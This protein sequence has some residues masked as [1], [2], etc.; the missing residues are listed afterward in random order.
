MYAAVAYIEKKQ[1]NRNIN[2]VGTRGKK[3]SNDKGGQTFELADGYRVLEDIKMTPNYW[4][5]AK[6]EMIAR[7]DNLGP[8]QL[9]FTLSCADMRW[10]ENFAAILLERGYEID[11]TQT[12]TLEDGSSETNIRARLKG[13]EWKPIKKFIEENLEESIHELVRG[14]VLTATRYFEH[15]VKQFIN[16]VMMGRNNPMH[17]KYYTY[18]VEFQDRGAGHIHGTLWLDIDR[19]ENM[20]IDSSSGRFRPKTEEEQKDVNC[21]G[22]MHGLKSAFKKLRHDGKL[23][24][25]E[26]E[27]LRKFIDT[28]T[29]V[30]THENTIGKRVA[31]IA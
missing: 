16:K 30:S 17:V 11:Y 20:V 25:N 12:H 23:T 10:N 14:N 2:L 3:V 6:Y 9:F 13:Q 15:R 19:I 29:T 28:Y 7:L 1:I 22:R 21:Q 8:F 26:K 31:N 5:K 24:S 18:K 27:S 4:K